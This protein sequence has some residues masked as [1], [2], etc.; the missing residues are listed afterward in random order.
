[1]T[2]DEAY[3]ILTKYITSQNLFRH[4]L[5]TEMVMRALAPKFEG[6]VETWGIVG[7]LHDAD[8]ELCKDHP[9]NHGLLL[10]E[11][12][13]NIPQDIMYAI[14]SH[15]YADT[16]VMPIGKM[17]WSITCCDELAAL[18]VAAA[19]AHPDKKLASLTVEYVI[20]RIRQKD[21]AKGAKRDA[22]YLCQEK[23]GIPLEEFVTIALIA[24][25]TISSQLDL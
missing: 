22:L 6:D 23:L 13:K 21:F 9:E 16:K 7:L 10:F 2:R 19:K 3:K 18:I 15:N 8:Y 1:M 20:N 17:D 4:A 5:A 14:K 24:I 12:E 25:Q 11:N